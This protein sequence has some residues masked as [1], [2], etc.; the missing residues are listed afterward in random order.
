[1]A[2]LVAWMICR[3]IRLI[4]PAIVTALLLWRETVTKATSY[5]RETFT[6]RFVYS[7]RG[8]AH[9]CHF[10]KQTGKWSSSWESFFFPFF[11][12]LFIKK[13]IQYILSTNPNGRN[14]NTKKSMYP[15]PVSCPDVFLYCSRNVLSMYKCIYH[16][17]EKKKTRDPNTLLPSMLSKQPSHGYVSPC[18]HLDLSGHSFF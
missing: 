5:K 18:I 4:M 9:D 8:L 6:W 7:F 1:M 11:L 2:V 14:R 17:W 3:W 10:G 12:F 15:V 13:I 16:Y